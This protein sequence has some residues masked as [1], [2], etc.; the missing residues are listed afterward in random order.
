MRAAARALRGAIA[1]GEAL[2]AHPDET[3]QQFITGSA[4]ETQIPWNAGAAW[5][6]LDPHAGVRALENQMRA[7]LG[8]AP[9]RR[10]G[11]DRNTWEAIESMVTLAGA[12]AG[13]S[14]AF[15]ARQ[16]DKW[17]QMALALPSVDRLPQWQAL[18]MRSPPDCPY[19]HTPNLRHHE[20]LG[21]VACLFLNCP[22]ITDGVRPW[23]EVGS[24]RGQLRWRWRDGM[25]QP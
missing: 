25:V 5:A 23:A 18:P 17:A 15:Y 24:K 19:C 20:A 1:A 13:E 6:V 16:L 8:L 7:E 21:I 22:A 2:I 9:V 10:G 4:A 11:S 14:Q 12:L 3:G